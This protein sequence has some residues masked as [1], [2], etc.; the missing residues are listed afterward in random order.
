MNEKSYCIFHM[1]RGG[2]YGDSPQ[3]MRSAYR[4]WGNI[5]GATVPDLSRSAG[6]G[7]RVART[8]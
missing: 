5:P 4:N 1:V 3:M 2:C 8:L 7:F 6:A